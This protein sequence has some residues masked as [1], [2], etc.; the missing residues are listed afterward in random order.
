MPDILSVLKFFKPLRL[1]QNLSD[2]FYLSLSD[3]AFKAQ[4]ENYV[5]NLTLPQK[6]GAGVDCA[7]FK[8]AIASAFSAIRKKSRTT[9]L[10]DNERW[11]F[12]NNYLFLSELAKDSFKDFFRLPHGGNEPRIV[13]LARFVLKNSG[14]ELVEERVDY[15]LSAHNAETPLT[16]R[17]ICALPDAFSF[18]LLEKIAVLSQ[19]CL[20]LEKFRLLS[21]S[22]SRVRK[23]ALTSALFRYFLGREKGFDVPQKLKYLISAVSVDMTRSVSACVTS[24]HKVSRMNFVPSYKPLQFLNS[25]ADF[26]KMSAATQAAY[27]EQIALES[28]AVNVNEQVYTQKLIELAALH[29]V[30]FGELLFK[31]PAATEDFIKRGEVAPLKPDKENKYS[32]R[33]FALGFVV[34][35]LSLSALPAVLLVVYAPQFYAVKIGLGILIF[36]LCLFILPCPCLDLINLFAGLFVKPRPVLKMNFERLPETAQTYAVVSEFIANEKDV[37]DICRRFECLKALNEDENITFMLLVDT[38]PSE[39]EEDENDQKIRAALNS[40]G[41]NYLMRKKTFENGK[42]RAAERKRGAVEAFFYALSANDFSAFSHV[43]FSPAKPQFVVLLDDDSML[44]PHAVKEA[45]CAMLHPLNKDYN[46]LS[47]NCKINLHSITTRYAKKF[48]GCGGREVYC[49]YSDLYFNLF[50]KSPF[51]GKGIFRVSG[52]MQHVYGKLPSN[53][54]LSHDIPE[55]ALLN[56]GSLS[57]C[58]FEDAPKSFLSDLN[59]TM[60][61]TRGDIQNIPFALSK[62]Y[63]VSAFYRMLILLNGIKGL[64]QIAMLSLALWAIVSLSA[65]LALLFAALFLLPWAVSLLSLA[66]KGFRLKPHNLLIEFFRLIFQTVKAAI[67]LPFDAAVALYLYFSTARRMISGK[68]LLEWKTF[69]EVQRQNQEVEG[70]NKIE[71]AHRE[72]LYRYARDFYRYFEENQVDGLIADHFQDFIGKG[73][74]DYT[75]S[76]NLGFSMLAHVA[77]CELGFI[78]KAAAKERVTATLD[79]ISNL[80]TWHG[81]LYNWYDLNTKQPLAPGFV[82]SVDSGNFVA[83]LYVLKGYFKDDADFCARLNL[84]IQNTRFEFLYDAKL[85]QFYIGFNTAAAKL[86]GH[87][88]MLESEAR[89]LTVVAIGQGVP[90]RAWNSLSRRHT[91]G[92][93]ST[94]FSWSGTCFEYLLADLFLDAPL[95]SML[96]QSSVNAARRQ[97]RAKC[98]GMFGVSEC[99]YFSLDDKNNFRYKAFGLPSLALSAER[100]CRVISPYSSFL[101]LNYQKERVLKNLSLIKNY[102]SDFSGANSAYGKY[103]FI[104][105]IDFSRHSDGR[106]VQTYM[107]HHQAMSLLAAANALSGNFLRDCFYFD[108]KTRAT[109]ILLTEPK[110]RT[111]GF[112]KPK[113]VCLLPVRAKN[114]VYERIDKRRLFPAFN[115]GGGNYKVLIDDFGQGYSVCNGVFINRFRPNLFRSYGC[116]LYAVKDGKVFCPTYAP[117]KDEADYAVEFSEGKSVFTNKTQGFVQEVLTS[118]LFSGELRRFEFEKYAKGGADKE[119]FKLVKNGEIIDGEKIKVAFYADL[120]LNGYAADAAHQS[121]SNLMVQTS[122]DAE[123]NVIYA[124]RKPRSK[125]KAMYAALVIK[126]LTDIVPVTSKFEFLGR[127][128]TVQNPLITQKIANDR[129]VF[130]SYGDV[131][132][133]CLGFVGAFDTARREGFSCAIVY[134]ETKAELEKNV[135]FAL[136]P[137]FCDFML[138]TG[139]DCELSESMKRYFRAALPKLLYSPYPPSAVKALQKIK[140][141]LEAACSKSENDYFDDLSASLGAEDDAYLSERLAEEQKNALALACEFKIL[142]YK[143]N[144]DL[145]RLNELGKVMERFADLNIDA[146][147]VV[148][149]DEEDTYF[150]SIKK[151]LTA[152]LSSGKFKLARY[153]HDIWKSVSFMEITD[154]LD[155]EVNEQYYPQKECPEKIQ[156]RAKLIE[157]EI[158]DQEDEAARAKDGEKT[159]YFEDGKFTLCRVPALPFSIVVALERGGYIAT[160]NGGG[161]TYFDNSR[162]NKLSQFY[163]DPVENPQSEQLFAL[164]GDWFAKLNENARTTYGTGCFL[165]EFVSE[166]FSAKIE[167]YLILSGGAKVYEIKIEGV[168]TPFT[169]ALT[170]DP[171]LSDGIKTNVFSTQ[172]LY[173][174]VIFRN[175]SSNSKLILKAVGGKAHDNA[176]ALLSRLKNCPRRILSLVEVKQLV[177]EIEVNRDGVYR[178][179]LGADDYIVALQKAELQEEKEQSTD[180][181]KN[182]SK[183]KIDT[184]FES[185]NALFND[186]LPAQIVCSRFF[187]RLGFYQTGGA[188]G[189]RD[190]LQDCL[191]VMK[192]SPRLARAMILKCAA[193]QYAEGDVMHWWHGEKHGV[194]TRISDDKLFLPY[195]ACEYV[196]WTGDASILEESVPFLISEKLNDGELNIAER[197]ED[198][199]ENPPYSE[200]KFPLIEHMER[201][202]KSALRY[203]QNGLLLIGSGD[204]NDAIND[205]GDDTRGESVWLSMFCCMVLEKMSAHY[206]GESKKSLLDEREKLAAAIE[207]CFASD[208]YKRLLTNNGEWMGEAGAAIEIDLLTQ[209]FSSLCGVCAKDRVNRA[210]DTAW[211]ELV[212]CQR[213][214]VRLLKPPV[215]KGLGYISSYPKGVRENGGQYTHAAVWFALALL[216]ENRADEAFE[217]LMMLNPAEKFLNDKIYAAYKA[218]P[219]VLAAD[220][221][222]SPEHSGRAGWTWYTG[223]AGWYYN[224]VLEMLGIKFSGKTLRLSPKIPQALDGTK[225]EFTA[226]GT[227]VFINIRKTGKPA[228]FLN[229]TQITNMS[230]FEL[231]NAKALHI[232]VRV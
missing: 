60:R 222:S 227:D 151:A 177:G 191:A 57:E 72:T 173:D 147:L 39:N 30:H 180:F 186:F 178:F 196:E 98:G 230:S 110:I 150:E 154:N 217:I 214:I 27:L 95:G 132:E 131:L 201:A 26:K 228:L 80:K 111:Y 112:K 160:E 119:K 74:A 71:D 73:S 25:D 197:E 205:A 40:F 159:G 17:E 221:Y 195:V 61:W 81:H 182:M 1:K 200:Q 125:E 138:K 183:F 70:D 190:Q 50:G 136:N 53:R 96:L 204:W 122:Y 121:F 58:V 91:A 66:F 103:G 77:A 67:F 179:I 45:V 65:P 142:F 126:G 109:K 206:G 170:I 31:N 189:F 168:K 6:S 155:I 202:V 137:S 8:K 216:N 145:N 144:G 220:V 198:R 133:P 3:E 158:K 209:A 59:R 19:K 210:L 212:D 56:S 207:K 224:T 43:S 226:F 194:R 75:S 28:D 63:R 38:K 165:Q 7:V 140:A 199:F 232:E 46:L 54:V 223:S 20:L 15:V 105:A 24:L 32:E 92:F 185:L 225:V 79:A 99:A 148:A 172:N 161:F 219:F 141:G 157:D 64:S 84:I 164:G 85:G 143:Y 76:T 134:A 129:E 175:L 97:T 181:F 100:E 101:A 51:C 162:E 211:R 68:R 89:I 37:E 83:S 171:A 218:E 108:P 22:K 14:Y 16:Y 93:E 21:K 102:N 23:K 52:Y 13:T 113:S 166:N 42:F 86:E 41:V 231:G 115:F 2:R 127:N 139:A 174:A 149:Y 192:I 156:N 117:V 87:Y 135:A 78:D 187:G 82:S 176:A 184:P 114:V 167:Q 123:L 116:F 118:P 47:F 120:C 49:G 106:A 9:E 146:L 94:L 48:V 34:F 4:T 203:G 130:A 10:F 128:R 69:G 55:G 11:L 36:L 124:Q 44:E 193:H 29:K 90:V 35:L 215:E 188:I 12:E 104:E 152:R 229:G 88:D 33:C 208:R 5:K 153:F 169:L 18:V 213:E 62:K 163:Q 107:A